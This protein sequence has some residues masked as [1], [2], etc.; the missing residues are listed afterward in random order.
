MKIL[1]KY[2]RAS[3]RYTRG[4]AWQWCGVAFPFLM[5]GANCNARAKASEPPAPL[6]VVAESREYESCNNTAACADDL[7]CVDAVCRRSTRSTVGDY[8]AAVGSRA[9]A[10]GEVEAAVS[11]FGEALVRYDSEKLPLPPDVDCAYGSA[12]AQNRARKEQAELAARVLHRC[13]VSTPV[14]SALRHRALLDLASLAEQGFDPATLAK[15]Q[16]ADVYLTKATD[17]PKAR[18]SVAVTAAPAPSAKTFGAVLEAVNAEGAKA[19]LLACWEP[20]RTATKRDSLRVEVAIKSRYVEPD[21][22]EDPAKYVISLEGGVGAGASAE[23]GADACVRGALD[24]ALRK[25][26]GLRDAFVTKLVVTYQ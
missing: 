12:L 23:V 15:T 1:S 17:A 22:I 14:G 11:A 21:Y 16:A 2:R 26:N 10:R 24:A 4:R 25:V 18:I 19:A 6:P 7:R 5:F 13:V 20:F 8:F 9:L 3:A